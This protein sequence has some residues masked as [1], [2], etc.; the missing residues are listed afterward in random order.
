MDALGASYLQADSKLFI[1]ADVQGYEREVLKGATGL[2]S[3]VVGLQL[4]MAFVPLYAGQSSYRELICDLNA[5]G[6]DLWDLRSLLVDQV[7]GRMLWADAV[8]FPD[9]EVKQGDRA[10]VLHEQESGRGL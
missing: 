1:K 10:V 5:L 7:T 6:F 8:F 9:M 4:E 3:S 2:W